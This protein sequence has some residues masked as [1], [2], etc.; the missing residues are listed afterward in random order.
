[1]NHAI[2]IDG[3]V[4]NIIWMVPGTRFE[5][6]VPCND[7]PVEIGDTYDD[8]VFYRKGE[9][10]LTELEKAEQEHAAEMAALIEEIYMEDLEMIG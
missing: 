8:G 6:A 9:K 2:V 10:V 1:M 7:V 4:E 5:H 3:I